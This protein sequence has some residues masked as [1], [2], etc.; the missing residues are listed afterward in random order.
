MGE[1]ERVFR[2]DF[3]P[4]DWLT[5]TSR[6]T[7]EQRG[8]FIQICAMIYANKGAIENDPAWI[9]N[10]ANC[11]PRLARSIIN[12]LVADGS[13]QFQGSKISQKRCENV[14][15][16]KRT[17]F[18]NSAKGGRKSSEIRGEFN[19]NNDITSSEGVSS[20]HTPSPS[21][22][23]S[24][25]EE[26]NIEGETP[27]NL[28][29]VNE[30]KEIGFFDF[31]EAFPRQRRGSRDKALAAYKSALKRAGK[32]AINDA[33]RKYAESDEVK[34]GFAKG[35]AAWLHDDR[36]TVDYGT[37]PNRAGQ[38]Q[39][40]KRT[41]YSDTIGEASQMALNNIERTTGNEI[42]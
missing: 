26:D 8:V 5:Q 32:D 27:E 35:A 6:M 4:H 18:E 16:T 1:L 40:T 39:Q 37:Q 31:W 13:L 36:W 9:G 7:L 34:R 22:S 30:E 19:E 12:Q 41:G 28:T 15:K 11:S 29:K 21:P 17:H 20:L 42:P 14:L 3:Y 33:T 24:P 25:K 23:P 38:N 10:L 2:V